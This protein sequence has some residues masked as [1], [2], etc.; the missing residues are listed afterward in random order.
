M[1]VVVS[2]EAVAAYLAETMRRIDEA[3]SRRVERMPAGSWA[4]RCVDCIEHRTMQ[5]LERLEA[6]QAAIAEYGPEEA[7]V[8]LPNPPATPVA[9][10]DPEG[11]ETC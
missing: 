8:E 11:D 2:R 10:T 4:D 1:Q 9:E 6:A 7:R 5:T 3:A